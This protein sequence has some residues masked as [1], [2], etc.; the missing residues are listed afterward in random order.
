MFDYNPACIYDFANN[1][2]KELYKTPAH[3]SEV[4]GKSYNNWSD[5]LPPKTGKSSLLSTTDE[6]VYSLLKSPLGLDWYKYKYSKLK[7]FWLECKA[8]LAAFAPRAKYIMEVGSFTDGLSRLRTTFDLVD[9]ATFVDVFKAQ[10]SGV[11][12]NG[13]PE[14]SATIVANNVDNKE[15]QVEVNENDVVT[16][17]HIND[18]VLVKKAM[19]DTI[20]SATAN[21]ATTIWI[22]ANSESIYYQNSLALI[23]E[24]KEWNSQNP[25]YKTTDG[26]T[27][28]IP[29]SKFIQNYESAHSDCIS[30][31]INT[32]ITNRPIIKLIKDI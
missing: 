29:I 25:N 15:I 27:I 17:G 21:G 9:M 6:E 18:Q 14:I 7:I 32:G 2:C 16:Q 8:I 13:K 20:K 5:I 11:D 1:F 28:N 31:G 26:A 22:I 3:A 4:H 10:F 24:F 12:W 23:G 30:A 19:F